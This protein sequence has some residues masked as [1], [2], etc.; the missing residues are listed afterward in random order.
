MSLP[1]S[2]GVAAVTT[3]TAAPARTTTRPFAAFEWMIALRY[4]RAKRRESFISVISI[5]SLIGITLGVATL[6]IVMSV[7]NGFREELLS[8]I[9]GFTGHM[10]IEAAEGGLKDFDAIA[11]RVRQVPGVTR[12]AP[13]VD[14]QVIVTANGVTRGAQVTGMRRDDIAALHVLTSSL[15]PDEETRFKAVLAGFNDPDTVIVG[16][17]LARRLGL[18]A[19]STI[20]LTAPKGDVTPFGTTPRVK[21]YTVAGTFD[22]GMSEYNNNFI[23]MLLPEAQLFF[24]EDGTVSRLEINVA[25]ADGV[26]SLYAPVQQAAGPYVRVSSWHDLNLALFD[27]VKIEHNVMFLILTLI[28]L[29]ASLNVIAGLIMLVKDKSGDIAILRTMGASRGAMMRIFLIAGASIGI[30]GTG[31]GL[32]VGTLFAYYISDIEHFVSWIAGMDVFSPEVYFLTHMP[33][34]IEP[35]DLF[36]VAGISLLLSLLATLYP[37]WRAA[38]LDPVEALRYE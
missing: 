26:D 24:N 11:A 15:K 36:A 20:T 31:I 18:F 25:D 9:L 16:S 28:V 13:V 34:K 29:V 22:A 14:G 27:A 12:V 21:T 30:V 23:F 6:I 3:P 19:G 1:T 10:K 33:S 32:A 8:R 37:S 17:G 7:M 35:F 4:L 38:R 2:A 5:I